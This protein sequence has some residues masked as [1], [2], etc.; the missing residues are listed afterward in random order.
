MDG[1]KFKSIKLKHLMHQ[2]SFTNRF[3][4]KQFLVENK[5]I[6]IGFEK[7]QSANNLLSLFNLIQLESKISLII[8]KRL[9]LLIRF[10]IVGNLSAT[11][12]SIQFRLSCG[13]TMAIFQDRVQPATFHEIKAIID[14]CFQ[15]LSPVLA[16]TLTESIFI[17]YC[18]VF[19]I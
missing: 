7:I 2:L 13:T 9:L 16:L 10:V 3:Y 6:S 19:S 14:S 12:F 18:T 4:I 17:L 15:H 8:E 11:L 1:L 5:Q